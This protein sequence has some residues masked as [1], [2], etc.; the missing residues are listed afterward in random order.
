M[1]FFPYLSDHWTRFLISFTLE[2]SLDGTTWNFIEDITFERP[3]KYYFVSITNK[4]R[5]YYGFRIVIKAPHDEDAY[6]G[7]I[8]EAILLNLYVYDFRVFDITKLR[9]QL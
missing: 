8:N 4:K 6:N 2:G 7:T 9:Y 1:S 3:D 5:A